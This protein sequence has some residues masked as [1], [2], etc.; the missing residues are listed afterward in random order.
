ME[1]FQIEE[2]RDSVADTAYQ[3][4]DQLFLT[5][6]LAAVSGVPS[7]KTMCLDGVIQ[8]QHIMILVDSGSS[9]TFISDQLVAKLSGVIPLPHPLVVQVANGHKLQC[10]SILP[11]AVFREAKVSIIIVSN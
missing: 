8:K 1:L 6:S 10:V 2:D 11:D 3:D 4:E 9:N 5:I 7:H